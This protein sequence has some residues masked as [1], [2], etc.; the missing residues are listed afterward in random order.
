MLD[1]MVHLRLYEYEYGHA[2]RQGAAQLAAGY[3]K[4]IV[5]KRELYTMHIAATQ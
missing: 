1:T 3:F 5:H 2:E 4:I